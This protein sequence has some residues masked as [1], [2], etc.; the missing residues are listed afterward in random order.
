MRSPRPTLYEHI[1][2]PGGSIYWEPHVDEA[3]PIPI[4]GKFYNTVEEAIEMYSTY[5]EAGGFQVKKSGQRLTKSGMVKHKYIMCNKEGHPRHINIDTLD[6]ANSDKQKRNTT[7]H[8]TGCKARIKLELDIVSGKYKLVQF[9]AQHNHVLIPKE[10][11]HFT[12]KQRKMTQAS[13]MFV[14]KAATNKIGATRAHHL[15]TSMKGGYEYVHGTTSDFKNHQRD[16]NAFIGESDAQ[17]LI[18]KMENRKKF[19]PNFTFEYKVENSEL[20]AFFWVDEVSKCNY[21]EFGDIVSFDATFR[22][23]K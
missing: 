20:V 16:I 23:N 13:K 8:V 10:Y 15:L 1:E 6:P 4:E 9:V 5:A 22:C 21:K 7:L 17:M 14:V 19:V 12:K 11:K 3:I 18:N 2:T